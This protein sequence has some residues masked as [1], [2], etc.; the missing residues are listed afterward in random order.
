MGASKGSRQAE[1]AAQ[2]R[3]EQ[4]RAE[5]SRHCNAVPSREAAAAATHLLGDWDESRVGHP[6]AVVAVG[7]LPQL[8]GPHLAKGHLQAVYGSADSII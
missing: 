3:A 7:H 6:G 2:S 1:E 8:V 4:S 5:Q